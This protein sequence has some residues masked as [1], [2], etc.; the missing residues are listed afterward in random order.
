SE[1]PAFLIDYKGILGILPHRYP[2]LFVDGVLAWEKEQS[3]TGQKNFSLN[4]TFFSGHFPSEPVVPGVIQI[5][6]LAQV[7]CILI[8]LSFDEFKGKRPAFTGIDEAKFKRPVR[9]GDI[10]VLKS[11]LQ[12]IRRGFAVFATKAEVGGELS[13]EAVIKAAMV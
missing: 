4:E 9:P 12:K 1:N 8:S 6:A 5:E 3:I 13:A 2:F 7:S 10:L 11:E